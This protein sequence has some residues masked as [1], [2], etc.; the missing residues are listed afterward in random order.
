MLHCPIDSF[1]HKPHF[2]YEEDYSLFSNFHPKREPFFKKDYFG[3]EESFGVDQF[4]TPEGSTPTG[5]YDTL[6]PKEPTNVSVDLDKQ[7]IFDYLRGLKEE[8]AVCHHD[9]R[10]NLRQDLFVSAVNAL[11]HPH[12][13]VVLIQMGQ[14]S[15]LRCVDSAIA[16]LDVDFLNIGMI[17]LLQIYKPV[18]AKTEKDPTFSALDRKVM[19]VL[20]QR[21]E[22]SSEVMQNF[23][24]DIPA[25]TVREDAIYLGNEFRRTF[26]NLVFQVRFEFLR[27]LRNEPN[28]KE[29]VKAK[30]A[31]RKVKKQQTRHYQDRALVCCPAGFYD[32]P[33]TP[34][35][36]PSGGG[37]WQLPRKTP[38]Y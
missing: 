8:L 36:K 17:F 6:T 25:P 18:D 23:A 31:P 20:N 1:H 22:K 32:P 35:F 30:K 12:K 38:R 3:V 26:M 14:E 16:D 13:D 37:F 21:H 27:K 34:F 4:Y 2:A 33:K 11:T 5:P 19:K 10:F 24:R 9:K 29:L 28:G 15:V 7:E